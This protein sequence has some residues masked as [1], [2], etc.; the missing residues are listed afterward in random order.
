MMRLRKRL[1]DL[2]ER[3]AQYTGYFAR[4][5]SSRRDSI[6]P[7]RRTVA[8]WIVDPGLK[9]RGA[10]AAGATAQVHGWGEFPRSDPAIQRRPTQRRDSNDVADSEEGRSR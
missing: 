1:P 2:E 3:S 9:C 7:F 6:R 5:A 4:A 8:F 10:P